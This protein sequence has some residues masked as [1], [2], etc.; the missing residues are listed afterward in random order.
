MPSLSA[1]QN[2]QLN[3]ED[4]IDSW[5]LAHRMRHIQYAEAAAFKGTSADAQAYLAQVPDDAWFLAHAAVHEVLQN[6]Y[7]PTQSVD[8][9]LLTQ[10]GWG[11]QSDFDTWMLAHTAMHRLLDE[12]FGIFS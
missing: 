10:Y 3:D 6:F 9:N 11:T 2:V 7:T 8:I 4:T 5:L 1:F 12:A